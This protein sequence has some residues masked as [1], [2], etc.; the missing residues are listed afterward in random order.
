MLLA[1]RPV[2]QFYDD[3]VGALDELGVHV[4]LSTLPSE[5]EAPVRFEDDLVDRDYDPDAVRRWWQAMLSTERVITRYRSPFHGKSSPVLFYWGG[6]DLDHSRFSGRNL[7]PPTSGPTR[8]FGEDQENFA[9]GFWP[10]S[11]QSPEPV[12]YAYPSPAPRAWHRPG[13]LRRS[14]AGSPRSGSSCFPTSKRDRRRRPTTWSPSSSAALT[15]SAPI[16]RPGTG[17]GWRGTPHETDLPRPEPVDWYF[18]YS[19]QLL[20]GIEGEGPSAS[21]P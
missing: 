1:G 21:H 20:F 3:V 14:P 12:L 15:T 8:E 6:F 16:W 17:P 11:A 13:S 4:Q 18:C 2:A 19:D 5:I 9:V 7:T 10:G